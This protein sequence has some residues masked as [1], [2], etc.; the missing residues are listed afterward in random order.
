MGSSSAWRVRRHLGLSAPGLAAAARRL[1]LFAAVAAALLAPWA[2]WVQVLPGTRAVLRDGHRRVPPRSRHLAAAGPSTVAALR[3]PDGGPTCWRG[4][5]TCSGFCPVCVCFSRSGG[6]S[7]DAS[8]GRANRSRS[9]AIAVMAVALD[10]TFLRNPLATRL[11]DATVP[12]ALLGA[13]LLGLVWSMKSPLFVSLSARAAAAVVVVCTL[14]R[15]L[16]PR[17]RQRQAR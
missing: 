6:G 2:L 11:A 15:H 17:R 14:G 8:D 3:R 13:W 7:P 12:A 5:T 10:A 4:C 9:V 1:A 16:G